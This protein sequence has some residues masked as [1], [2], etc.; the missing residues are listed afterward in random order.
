[1]RT[2]PRPPL[3]RLCKDNDQWP[4]TS[5]REANSLNINNNLWDSEYMIQ[6][7]INNI[8]QCKNISL[9]G[10][11]RIYNQGIKGGQ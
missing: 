9:L 4:I 8:R 7:T 3:R 6:R 2:T 5:I 11:D 10:Y 1:M